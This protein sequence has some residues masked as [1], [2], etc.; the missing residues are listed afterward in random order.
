MNTNLLM[1]VI[2]PFLDHAWTKNQSNIYAVATE[3]KIQAAVSNTPGAIGVVMVTSLIETT[4]LKARLQKP[5]GEIVTES[6]LAAYRCMADTFNSTTF[7]YSNAVSN[8]PGCWPF[9]TFIYSLVRT[10][11]IGDQCTNAPRALTF[12]QFLHDQTSRSADIA[13]QLGAY[14]T[15]AA[16]L[17]L[18]AKLTSTSTEV[19]QSSTAA[20]SLIAEQL[21]ALWAPPSIRA[22]VQA[23]LNSIT[24]E[25]ETILVTLPVDHR[26]GVPLESALLGISV[27]GICIIALILCF[28][29]FFHLRTT[30][31]ASSPIFLAATI[32]GMLFL[33][34]SGTMIARDQPTNT[35]CTTGWWMANIGFYLTFGPLFAKSW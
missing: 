29:Y 20:T 21:G 27:I 8:A 6:V 22:L 11:N 4:T 33:F 5:N 9:T 25:G 28:L 12:L 3:S 16:D 15:D 18:A 32:I 1:I 7:K 23:R 17:A 13:F 34:I 35:L 30:I 19:S 31:K 2:L 14:T 26:L 24:C 10:N